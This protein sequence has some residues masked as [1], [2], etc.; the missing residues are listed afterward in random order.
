MRCNT[1]EG[2]SLAGE[3]SSRASRNQ[4]GNR[5]ADQYR[6][7]PI[8]LNRG[9]QDRC[10]FEDHVRVRAAQPERGDPGPARPFRLT[11]PGH[12]LLQQPQAAVPVDVRGRLVGVQ[13]AR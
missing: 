9:F 6:G 13:G 1:F 7:S 3:G 8:V 10:F 11:R 2:G 12:R 5:A 4:P